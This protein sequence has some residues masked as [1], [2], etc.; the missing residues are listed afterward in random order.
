MKNTESNF[1]LRRE[2]V[3]LSKE[4]ST[5]NNSYKIIYNKVHAIKY[6]GTNEHDILDFI[7]KTKNIDA[8]NLFNIQKTNDMLIIEY[9]NPTDYYSRRKPIYRSY[10]ILLNQWIADKSNSII[11]DRNN[12]NNMYLNVL[13]DDCF[14]S[15]VYYTQEGF[16][17]LIQSKKKELDEMISFFNN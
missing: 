7:S 9:K 16:N 3:E 5:L 2:T 14:E 12:E 4:E 1:L 6:N 11:N 8:H 10:K 15:K 13:E 17:E